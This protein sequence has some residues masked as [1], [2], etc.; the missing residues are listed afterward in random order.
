MHR[1][2]QFDGPIAVVGDAAQQGLFDLLPIAARGDGPIVF[3][4]LSDHPTDSSA[5][6]KERL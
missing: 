6:T 4:P 1:H 5:R 2:P 3:Q